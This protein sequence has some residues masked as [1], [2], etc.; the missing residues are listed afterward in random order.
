L[1]KILIDV[2][3]LCRG[4]ETLPFF[5]PSILATDHSRWSDCL[6]GSMSGNALVMKG[7][8]PVQKGDRSD[9]TKNAEAS[10]TFWWTTGPAA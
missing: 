3:N 5:K 9:D 7:Y 1:D 8:K 4:G 10:L 6:Q 2:A